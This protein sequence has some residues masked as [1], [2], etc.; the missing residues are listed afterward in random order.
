MN[1]TYYDKSQWIPKKLQIF[2]MAGDLADLSMSQKLMV[3]QTLNVHGKTFGDTIVTDRY[4]NTICY[5]WVC[6]CRANKPMLFKIRENNGTVAILNSN[7]YAGLPTSYP[8]VRCFA[9]QDTN[10]LYYVMSTG[11]TWREYLVKIDKSSLAMT[12]IE[13]YSTYAWGN[14]FKETDTFVFHARKQGYGTNIVKRY[15]KITATNETIPVTAKTGNIYFSTCY[16]NLLVNSDTDFYTFAIYQNTTTNKFGIT[17]YHFDTTQTVLANICTEADCNITWGSGITQ[18]PLYA[19]AASVHYEPFITYISSSNKYYLNIAIY[20]VNGSTT[21]NYPTYGIYTFLIDNTT[22]DLTFKNFTT[23]TNDCFRGFIGTRSNTFL[24]SAS[25]TSTFFLN[26]DVTNEKFNITNTL[27]NQPSH[28]GVDQSE[29]IWIVNALT[30]VE[31]L[32]SYV[33]TNVYINPEF[34]SMQQYNYQGVDLSSFITIQATNWTGDNVACKLKL[35]IKGGAVFTSNNSKIITDTTLTS[36]SKTIPITIKDDTGFS[37][38]PEA[39]M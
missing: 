35:T 9:G 7:T 23:V 11:A 16:S 1:G 10:F 28:I 5:V 39:I 29:G 26:F 14:V 34:T 31:F 36:G 24:I 37:I 30:E 17:R 2:P 25:P 12:T 22:K 27:V 8:I 19:S 4:D 32:H 38:Y 6:G 21:A 13:D 18:L 33:P 20:E 15:N 3:N